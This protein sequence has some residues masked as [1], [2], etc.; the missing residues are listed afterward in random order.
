MKPSINLA[1]SPIR[2]LAPTHEMLH[3]CRRTD[4]KRMGTVYLILAFIFSFFT[5]HIARG[6]FLSN[7]PLYQDPFDNAAG[8]ASITMASREGL[9]FSNP[10]L[11]PF[12]GKIVRWV[13]T[14]FNL[15]GPRNS[16][17]YAYKAKSE[18][19]SATTG[20]MNGLLG[21]NSACQESTQDLNA[22]M[23]KNTGFGVSTTLS[24][25]LNNF[26][27]SLVLGQGVDIKVRR[28]G[29]PETGMGLPQLVLRAESANALALSTATRIPYSP[30]SFG[31]T[32][33]Y[34]ALLDTKI[35]LGTELASDKSALKSQT[36]QIRSGIAKGTGVDVGSLWFTQGKW[37]DFRLGITVQDIGN[38]VLK[39]IGTP[40]DP[41]DPDCHSKQPIRYQ[42]MNSGVGLTFH[43]ST[44]MIHF[45][46]DYRDINNAYNEPMFKRIYAGTKITLR[47]SLGLAFGM[48]HG[49]PSY[50]V[51]LDAFI[52]KLSLSTWQKVYGVDPKGDIRKYFMFSISSGFSL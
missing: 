32:A 43:N 52:F 40:C 49:Y 37:I 12:G 47:N 10:A 13:G 21:G 44:D 8:G 28:A 20:A 1:L 48:H 11:I 45:A 7:E 38:A 26:A 41:T 16:L 27:G 22:L 36:D 19:C 29:D 9:M 33:K 30:L 39:S 6:Q 3:F 24:G 15:M 25:I 51:E 14:K 46:L 18:G 50:G 35:A 23:G 42:T 34:M 2:I 17:L 5:A 4:Y 31:L